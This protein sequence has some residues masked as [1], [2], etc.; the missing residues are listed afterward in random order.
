[1]GG[2]DPLT[3]VAIGA[4][5]TMAMGIMLVAY[6]LEASGGRRFQRGFS[7]IVRQP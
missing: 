5:L 4:G 7:G 6:S 2:L 3:M 1:M